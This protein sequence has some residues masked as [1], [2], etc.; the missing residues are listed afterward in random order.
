VIW[1][2][3]GNDFNDDYGLAVLDQAAKTPPQA[4]QETPPLPQSP[5]A[6]WLRA[7]STLYGIISSLL[8]GKNPGID[9]FVDPYH[10]SSGKV[11]LRFGQEYIRQAFDLSEPRNQEGEALSY[12]AILQT[13]DLVEKNGGRF[14]I[15]V[16][17]T[18]E[19]VYRPLTEPLIGK[20]AVDSIATPRLHLLDFCKAQN[21]TCLDLLPKLQAHA[22]EQLYYANDQHLN[23]AGN[24]VTAWEIAAFLKGQTQ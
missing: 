14:V 18:K 10:A 3:Y 9:K 4:S 7:N 17:P 23:A 8:R 16:M 2:F 20:A 24:E 1:Q 11:S 19:E 13:R 22:D 12:S 15:V 21:L 6:I 5:L